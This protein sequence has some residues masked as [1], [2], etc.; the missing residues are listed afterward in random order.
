MH[1]WSREVVGWVLIVVG[2]CLFYRCYSLLAGGHYILEGGTLAVVGIVVFRGGIHLLKIAVAARVCLQ[3][4]PSLEEARPSASRI[5]L[6][7]RPIPQVPQQR[8]QA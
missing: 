2:L 8:R 6:P 5:N 3:A 7:R 4:Q 1:F